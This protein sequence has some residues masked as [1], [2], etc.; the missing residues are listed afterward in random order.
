MMRMLAVTMLFSVGLIAGP[1]TAQTT[2]KQPPSS[3]AARAM[4]ELKDNT[5]PYPPGIYRAAIL[6]PPPPSGQSSVSCLPSLA[7]PT[8]S[9][10][11]STQPCR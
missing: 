3:E 11:P 2:A 4:A 5:G 7:P 1:A 9:L 6:P 8:G 10:S